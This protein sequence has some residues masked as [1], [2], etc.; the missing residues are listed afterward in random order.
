MFDV[1]GVKGRW[2]FFDFRYIHYLILQKQLPRGVPNEMC[3]AKYLMCGGFVLL[4]L[5]AV[6]SKYNYLIVT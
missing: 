1:Q 3:S 5:P 4:N 2:S 6:E